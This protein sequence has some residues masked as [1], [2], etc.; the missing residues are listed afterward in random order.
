MRLTVYPVLDKETT[1][2]CDIVLDKEITN[3][4]NIMLHKKITHLH[5]LVFDCQYAFVE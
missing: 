1:H 3:V 5:V 2:A 4:Y